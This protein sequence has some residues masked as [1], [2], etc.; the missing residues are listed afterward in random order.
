MDRAGPPLGG[1]DAWMISPSLPC[2]SLS[3]S[4]FNSTEEEAHGAIET[5]LAR[6]AK[7]ARRACRA[8]KMPPAHSRA[9]R[10]CVWAAL[11]AG[12]ER[13]PR[14]GAGRWRARSHVGAVVRKRERPRGGRRAWARASAR[15]GL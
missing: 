15:R 10:E 12:V 14:G 8:R 13:A 2:S 9:V 4:P 11:R 1:G 6:G 3:P 7:W 5:L